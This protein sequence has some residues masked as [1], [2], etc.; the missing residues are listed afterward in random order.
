MSMRI[1]FGVFS[2]KRDVGITRDA[3]T[4]AV[5][6]LM[7]RRRSIQAYSACRASVPDAV[8]V[9]QNGANGSC[10]TWTGSPKGER[11]GASESNA[12]QFP[13]DATRS[14]KS[15]RRHRRHDPFATDPPG[16]RRIIS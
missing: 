9:S 6:I 5:D 2:A 10:A 16:E 1:G 3:S 13:H 15:D 11:I 8:G 7:K 4:V 12:L 14:R